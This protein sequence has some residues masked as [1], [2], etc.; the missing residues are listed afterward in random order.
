M[1]NLDEVKEIERTTKYPE[2]AKMAR[3]L[4]DAVESQQ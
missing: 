3:K 1:S 2:V 4:I